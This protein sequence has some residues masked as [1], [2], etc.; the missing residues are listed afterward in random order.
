MSEHKI[1][2]ERCLELAGLAAAEGESAVGSVVV[3]D[4]LIIGEAFE[5]SRQ[6]KDVTRHAE[7]LAIFDAIKKHGSC[8]G[9]TLYSN[10]EPCI[11]CS[12][13][14]RHHKLAKVVFSKHCGE[15]GG[16]GPMFP[17][18]ATAGI[19]G[20]GKPPVVIVWP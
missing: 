10:V 4:G 5:R 3:K 11:L 20:W 12:Y 7:V 14:I 18:L 8:A 19:K 17:L 1:Y 13:V 2:I 16:S 6:L 9:A 15:L